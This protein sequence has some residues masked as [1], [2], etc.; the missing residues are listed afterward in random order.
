M[1]KRTL[2]LFVLAISSIGCNTANENQKDLSKIKIGMKMHSV[3]S[4]MR[5]N[6]IKFKSKYDGDS[7]ITKLYDAPIGSSGDYEIIYVKK[8]STVSNIYY[9]N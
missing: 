4:I 6:P 3:D 5:N 7:I 8:D 1:K 9:G 2:I